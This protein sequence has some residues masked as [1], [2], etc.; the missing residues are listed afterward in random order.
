[1][2][3]LLAFLGAFRTLAPAADADGNGLIN[4]N[5]LLAFLG[6]FRTGCP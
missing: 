2:N 3:D 6:A 1:M 4:V 5:D